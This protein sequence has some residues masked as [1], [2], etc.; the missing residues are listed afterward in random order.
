MSR[1]FAA[2]VCLGVLWSA[3]ELAAG[4]PNILL[5]I[6]DD[7]SWTDFGFMGHKVIKIAKHIQLQLPRCGISYTYRL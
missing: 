1:L 4:Q 3:S 6:S 5:I 2:A 7:Q